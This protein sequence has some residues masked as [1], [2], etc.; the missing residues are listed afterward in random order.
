MT[1]LSLLLTYMLPA[2]GQNIVSTVPTTP[3]HACHEGRAPKANAVAPNTS[4]K[5]T[6]AAC[7]KAPWEEKQTRKRQHTRHQRLF[8][9]CR[10]ITPRV[11]NTP[12]HL[13]RTDN[14]LCMTT[15]RTSARES[16]GEV[17]QRGH[18]HPEDSDQQQRCPTAAGAASAMPQA[19]EIHACMHGVRM[20]PGQRIA[21]TH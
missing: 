7:V 6:S 3:W 12:T 13:G 1:T 17:G 11:P 5:G 15:I 8:Q 9:T 14:N 16:S 18:C 19:V 2:L 4:P 21:R 20:A 10:G